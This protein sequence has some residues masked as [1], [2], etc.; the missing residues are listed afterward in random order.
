MNLTVAPTIYPTTVSSTKNPMVS[1]TALSPTISPVAPP[2]PTTPTS[3]EDT[4]T[5][6]PVVINAIDDNE[7]DDW[8]FPTVCDED[9]IV[10]KQVC[11]TDIALQKLRPFVLSVKIFPQA[12]Y[13]S[14]KPGTH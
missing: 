11:T 4:V 1:P 12:G 7:N 6:P 13:N 5:K 10:L 2:T 3:S 14:N 8:V 9:I